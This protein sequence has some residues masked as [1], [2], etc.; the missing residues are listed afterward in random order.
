MLLRTIT[1][2][3]IGASL[4]FFGSVSNA[5]DSKSTWSWATNT[6]VTYQNS[7][8]T[9]QLVPQVINSVVIITAMGIPEAAPGSVVNPTPP[10][11]EEEEAPKDNNS[12]EDFLEEGSLKLVQIDNHNDSNLQPIGQGT[13]FFVGKNLIL[14]NHHVI[15][16]GTQD[17]YIVQ[18]YTFKYKWYKARVIAADEKTDLA[19]LEITNPDENSDA[20]EPLK[21]ADV[22][23]WT[24]GEK[25]FA[26]GHPHGL[27]WT[28]T[29][30]VLSHPHRRIA[31]PWQWLIQTDT[32]VN[33]GNSG[34]PLFN[35]RGEVVGVNVLLLGRTEEGNPVDSGLNFA[36]RSDL[37]E[38]VAEEL[39]VHKRVRR[40]RIGMSVRNR[41]GMDDLGI[42]VDE[43]S[44]DSPAQRSELLPEDIITHVDNEPI[45]TT[46]EFFV[47][48][49]QKMPGDKVVF[50][51]ERTSE[52]RDGPQ[53]FSL[54][55]TVLLEELQ[56]D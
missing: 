24:L 35:M 18:I 34:G 54:N 4:L 48:F 41:Q 31:T 5:G 7:Q 27:Y 28:V 50:K 25:L 45:N 12:V 39:R 55:I 46:Y 29:E 19:I 23:S 43:L 26:I 56:E 53:S 13:G 38:H 6:N 30:G 36:V 47:W 15:E 14:T 37:A 9:E 52:N 40:P 2:S 8:T 16:K 51:V 3:I 1:N 21:F 49:T 10:R 44:E 33:P 11:P 17:E 22:D 42:I 20:V 32:S